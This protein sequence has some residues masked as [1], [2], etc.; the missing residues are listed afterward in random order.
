M[1]QRRTALYLVLLAPPRHAPCTLQ[2]ACH[3]RPC[4]QPAKQ[5]QKS[6]GARGPREACVCGHRG[7]GRLGRKRENAQVRAFLAAGSSAP[8]APLAALASYAASCTPATARPEGS[9]LPAPRH[10]TPRTR[11]APPRL[12]EPAQQPGQPL[13]PRPSAAKG[14][15]TC[16]CGV[17]E[18]G[19][20]G[21]AR[22]RGPAGHRVGRRLLRKVRLENGAVPVRLLGARRVVGEP[23]PASNH[24]ARL[25]WQ[26]RP[27]R[28]TTVS[29]RKRK[30]CNTDALH[31]PATAHLPPDPAPQPR[32]P[33]RTLRAPRTC[34][35]PA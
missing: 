22:H 15:R 21:G 16:P 4:P 7:G 25:S 34:A 35:A 23:A 26:H 6:V 19:R 18:R 32:P 3:E 12:S 31:T 10:A 5:S 2:H 8:C 11:P 1:C 28:P 9:S 20:G 30:P 29:R 27:A 24:H 14:A 17:P 33:P 13:Q